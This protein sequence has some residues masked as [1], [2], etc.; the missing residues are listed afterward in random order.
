[1]KNTIDKKLMN[2]AEIA[3]RIGIS[4]PYASQILNGQRTG[5]K[6]QKRLK[7]IEAEIQRSRMLAA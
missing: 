1:M 5:P 4:Q 3:R 6:A 2:I 7:E